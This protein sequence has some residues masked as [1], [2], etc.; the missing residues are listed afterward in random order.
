MEIIRA[1]FVKVGHLERRGGSGQR[2]VYAKDAPRF[3][4]EK[5]LEC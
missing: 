5:L 3:Q 1:V 4:A 2:N